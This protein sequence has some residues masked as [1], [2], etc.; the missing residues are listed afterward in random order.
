M[1]WLVRLKKIEIACEQ[2]ATEPT[3]AS[4]VGFVAPDMA[5]MPKTGGNL[6]AANDP[7]PYPDRWCWPHSEAMNGREIDTFMARVA[8]FTGKGL[9]L[10]D[11]E[12]LADKLVR[13]DREPDDRGL[14]L[15]CIHLS[16]QYGKA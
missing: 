10:D 8:R 7:A 14:C 16:G 6:S 9:G 12:A 13:R 5:L 3:K 2:D 1:N 11:A 15:E 4:F